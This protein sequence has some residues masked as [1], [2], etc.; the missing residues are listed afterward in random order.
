MTTD[1]DTVLSRTADLLVPPLSEKRREWLDDAR[2]NQI[3]P[4]GLWEIWLLMTGR[5]WGKTRTGAEDI[6][7]YMRANPGHRVALVA[8][9]FT[10]GRDTMVEGESGL[11]AC[12]EDGTYKWNR[13]LGELIHKNGSRAKIFSSEK[14]DRLRGPQHHRAWC[15]EL[16]SWEYLTDT[17][18]NLM[19]GLRL[20]DHPR[21]IITT[22]PRPLDLIKELVKRED[23][24]VVVV[25]GSTYEN[26]ENLSSAAL[27]RLRSKYEGT[28]LGR[29]ELHG[30]ILD[31]ITG[32]LWSLETI[33]EHRWL[34]EKRG[35]ALLDEVEFRRLVVSV[36][37]A[38]TST[39]E[40]DW[41]GVIVIGTVGDCPVCSDRGCALV[42]DDRT[43]HDAPDVWAKAVVG[44]YEDWRADCVIGEV[45]QGGDLVELNLRAADGGK[46]MAYETVRATRGKAIRAQPI[47]ALYA[48][49]RV[50]HVGGFPKLE[51][52]LTS[53]SPDNDEKS[54]DRLDALVWGATHLL[55]E[56]EGGD[57]SSNVF[58][59]A[60]EDLSR[61]SY[62]RQGA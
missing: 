19:F 8:A 33:E 21:T 46:Q 36:D 35:P 5:G 60:M 31:Q 38:V 20:G 3:T 50:H 26:E 37:P 17:W 45:N 30:E 43:L 40:S 23:E 6:A 32:A 57:V 1:L 42:L 9:T 39:D 55:L 34:P 56:E 52:E 7:E 2:P 48:Q 16:A 28:T 41:T 61:G 4:E 29:Q 10:D 58:G 12:L 13:S 44:A 25:T 14:P 54:P 53:W 15:D 51:D 18:D 47:A 11:E 59:S 27:R 24:S 49:G 22:T 62:W